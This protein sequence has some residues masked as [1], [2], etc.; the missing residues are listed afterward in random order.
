MAEPAGD[1]LKTQAAAAADTVVPRT[2]RV[3]TTLSRPRAAETRR[4]YA[5]DWAG[6]AAWCRQQEQR[7]LPAAP[8]AVA[9]YLASLSTALAPGALARRA[10]AIADRHRSTGH[11]SPGADAQVRAVLRAARAARRVAVGAGAEGEA[12]AARAAGPPRAS[13]ARSSAFRRAGAVRSAAEAAQLTRMAARCPGNLAGL[14]DRVLLLLAA[15]GIGGDQL[16][17][18]DRE[19]VRLTDQQL[20]LRLPGADPE[21]VVVIPRAAAAARCPVR[22][23]D[24]WLG[25]SDTR[26]GPVFRKVDRWGNVEQQRLR[27]DGLRRIWQ[28]RVVAARR[29]RSRPAATP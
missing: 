8:E 23:L 20:A 1:H 19:H 28:R 14:R 21:A 22:A 11:A 29:S 27:A 7:P 5:A 18:L 12:A 10:A 15:A 4:L 26:F 25:I 9:A 6:F 2:E 16:L 3:S 17:A 13:A 24:S